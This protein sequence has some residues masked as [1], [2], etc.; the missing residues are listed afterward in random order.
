MKFERKR[1]CCSSNSSNGDVISSNGTVVDHV[2]VTEPNHTI[3]RTTAFTRLSR[4]VKA[5]RVCR[6]RQ[7]IIYGYGAGRGRGGPVFLN[8]LNLLPQ[9]STGAPDFREYE[10]NGGH[11]KEGE[12]TRGE[13][14]RVSGLGGYLTSPPARIVNC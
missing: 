2:R 9:E 1:S 14:D 4:K 8:I 5:A 11:E 3:G 7:V 12:K 13:R 10:G 6:A